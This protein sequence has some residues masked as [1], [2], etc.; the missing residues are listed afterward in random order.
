[1]PNGNDLTDEE[2]RRLDEPLCRVDET[3]V[4]FGRRVIGEL[5]RDHHGHPYRWLRLRRLGDIERS[6]HLSPYVPSGDYC[7]V[8]RIA[9]QLTVSM[10]RDIGT[11]RQSLS[12][13]VAT[14]PANEMNSRAVAALLDK[15][16]KTLEAVDATKFDS[17]AT[18]TELRAIDASRYQPP[19]APF[20]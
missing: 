10:W 7:D 16:M 6:I 3:L 9:F 1:M 20:H 2:Y 12:E 5:W 13:H 14:I 18:V 4:D 19:P 11:V 15:A 17:L 8:S